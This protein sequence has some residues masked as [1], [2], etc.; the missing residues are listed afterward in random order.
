VLSLAD[1][2]EGFAAALMDPALAVPPG[3][4]GPDGE[5]SPR[6]FAVYRNNV[7]VGLVGALKANYPAVCRIVGEEFF[8][9]MARVFV[10]S[11]PPNSPILLDYGAGFADFIWGF[12]PVADLPYLADVAR[13]ERAWLESYHAPEAKPL[14]PDALAAIPG[15]EVAGLTLSLHPSLRQVW[16]KFPV[17]TIW[18]MNIGD[19]IPALVDFSTGGEDVLVMR[20]AAEVEVRAMPPGGFEFV[21]ALKQGQSLTGAMKKA[22]GADPR[23]DLSGNIRD[24]VAAGAFI[25]CHAASEPGLLTRGI[26]A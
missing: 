5:P 23:F 1:R 20:A 13:L 12:E 10:V 9:A 25:G 16:S 17:L 22:L 24:L 14:G 15:D 21:E 26:K 4:V 19:G 6:R 11:E 8:D 7:I 18:R 2:L 3:L